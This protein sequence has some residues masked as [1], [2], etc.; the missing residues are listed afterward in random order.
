MPFVIGSSELNDDRRDPRDEERRDDEGRRVHPVRGARP[1]GREEQ[2]GATR[3]RPSTRCARPS[4]GARSPARGR[5]PRRGSGAPAQTAG[6]KKPVATPLTAA[7][8]TISAGSSTNGSATNVPARTR[9]ETIIRRR[10]ESRSTSGPSVS[11]SRRSGGSPRSGARRASGPT[12]CG[13][14]CRRRARVPRGTSRPRTRGG[15]EEERE[16]RVPSERGQSACRSVRHAPTLPPAERTR[17][18]AKR[19][20][21]PGSPRARGVE[22]ASVRRASRQSAAPCYAA[23]GSGT[24]LRREFVRQ[25][26]ARSC[27]HAPLARSSA[28]SA[29]A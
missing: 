2:A 29:S 7:S 23:N 11:R 3:A 20:V 14:R 10:R 6:R 15:P 26:V 27:R 19:D 24:S 9:S 1:P 17:T 18:V 13:R 22:P 16:A 8:A 5:R 25:V 12:P 28:R 21:Y 4:R